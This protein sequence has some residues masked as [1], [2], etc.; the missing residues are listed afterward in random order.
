MWPNIS[1]HVDSGQYERDRCGVC[2]GIGICVVCLMCGDRLML[3][4]FIL[5]LT[6]WGSQ[7]ARVLRHTRA[8]LHQPLSADLLALA[9]INY[10]NVF[11][12][13]KY[14]ENMDMIVY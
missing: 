11:S 12:S 1:H 9:I 5:V 14:P 2:L 7:S 13:S 6:H 10:V 4:L 3:A 8:G